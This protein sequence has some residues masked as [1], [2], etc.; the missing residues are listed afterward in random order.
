[1]PSPFHTVSLVFS[2]LGEE[3]QPPDC[4]YLGFKHAR[5]GSNG[6]SVGRHIGNAVNRCN[7]IAV[8]T[9][10]SEEGWGFLGR[11]RYP[12]GSDVSASG[13]GTSSPWGSAGRG[14]GGVGA[15]APLPART[16]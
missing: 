12:D 13:S 10:S 6:F 5:E 9:A 16:S 8:I 4:W 2:Y 15:Y 7:G 3:G 14:A 1:M 11:P